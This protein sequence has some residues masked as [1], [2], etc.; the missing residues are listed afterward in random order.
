MYI[1]SPKQKTSL[2]GIAYVAY[3]GGTVMREQHNHTGFNKQ[4]L[5][6]KF[7]VPISYNQPAVQTG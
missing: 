4:L 6:K 2:L 1:L 7:A 3:L 5:K